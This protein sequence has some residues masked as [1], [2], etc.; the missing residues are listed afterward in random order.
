MKKIASLLA[1]V[2]IVSSCTSSGTKYGTL[3]KVSDK[4]IVGP[5]VELAFEGG[6][7][8][9]EGGS[10]NSQEFKIDK[11]GFDTLSKYVGKKVVVTYSDE[12][13]AFVGTSKTIN[14]ISIAQ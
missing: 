5:V 11:A 4:A 14:S 7:S 1:I 13:F 12:G 8:T 3:Q 2:L 6:R 10:Q 9:E